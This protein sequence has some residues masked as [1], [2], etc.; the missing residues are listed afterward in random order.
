M[1]RPPQQQWKAHEPSWRA[2]PR[3][4]LA[5]LSGHA[6]SIVQLQSTDRHPVGL[7]DGGGFGCIGGGRGGGRGAGDGALG[8]EHGGG[9][10]GGGDCWGGGGRVGSGGDVGFGGVSGGPG[11]DGDG[12]G[13]GRQ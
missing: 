4:P 3:V 1:Y 5:P 11:G 9:A 10:A 7:L 12:S 13:G 6:Y 8:F 2:K